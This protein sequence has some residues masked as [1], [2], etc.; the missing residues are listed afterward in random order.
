MEITLREMVLED[1]APAARL[2]GQLGYPCTASEMA[3]RIAQMAMSEQNQAWVAVMDDSLLGWIQVTK[4]F[5]L[6][7]GEFAEITGLIVDARARGAGAGRRLVA[8]A[9]AWAQA[10]GLTRLV[11]RMNVTRHESR[12]F[13]QYL[14]FVENKQQVVWEAPDK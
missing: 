3:Q 5:R 9:Q 4:M 13:Y 6:E 7:S 2:S 12:G 14:G 11:V 8:Q 1:A 10:Q